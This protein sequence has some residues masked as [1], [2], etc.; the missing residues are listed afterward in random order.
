V[1]RFVPIFSNDTLLDSMTSR[2]V[3]ITGIGPVTPVGIG[4]ADFWGGL[5]DAKSR[6]VTIRRFREEAGSFVG[7]EVTDF[8]IDRY[9][10]DIISK[11][12]PRHTQFAIAA[13]ALALKD[14]QIS[15]DE[16]RNHR[17]A[18]FVGAALMDFGTINKSV[19]LILRRGPI[20]GLPTAISSASVSAIGSAIS[21]NLQLPSTVGMSFQSACC[22]GLDAI[23][24]AARSILTGEVDIAI[25]G[26]TEA[27]IYFH[28]MLELR[29]AGLAPGNPDLP[30]LQC[31][32][33]DLWRTTGI[34][35]EGACMFILERGDSPRP[36]YANVAGYAYATD[37]PGMLCSGLE[38]AMS[39]TLLN[40]G[41]RPSEVESIS[42]WG[43]GHR[44]IDRAESY[45]LSRT[46]GRGLCTIPTSS[47][48]GALGNPLGAAGAMQV[49][50]AALG[51]RD[52]LIPPTVNW[53][54]PDPDCQLSLD[55]SPRYI[56]HGNSLINSHGISGSNACLLI[57]R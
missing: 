19:E 41:V 14:A 8:L 25:C 22:S 28:P 31:R 50:A 44:E 26:G 4:K 7:A 3:K 29:M 38:K 40:A 54:R 51:I 48:K 23:G 34:I 47:I 46:F 24:H 39:L 27:P 12:M 55:R 49:A 53:L 18:V 17:V 30:E 15:I 52:G 16:L 13:S 9:V 45:A 6:A 33:F 21:E 20:N 5:L 1:G 36:S 35:G 57:S 32:P 56:S 11:R 42:A 37:S 2:K 43:P 10:L